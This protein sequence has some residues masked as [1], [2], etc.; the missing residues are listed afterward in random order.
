MVGTDHHPFERLICWLERWQA[1]HPDEFEWIVQ[2][3]VTRPM[4]D[5][6]GFAMRPRAEILELLRTAAVVVTQ[7]G[8]GGIMDAREC[9]R[10]PI[11]VPRLAALRE[12]VDDHQVSFAA[13]LADRRLAVTATSEPELHRALDKAVHDPGAYRAAVVPV[14]VTASVNHLEAAAE[15]LLT[16]RPGRPR[17]RR[18]ETRG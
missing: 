5:G 11:V 17:W 18:S 2:H 13:H 8:P 15:R 4:Q 3:G 9:G 1:R 6:T 14:D 12:A 10:L 7:A 16:L